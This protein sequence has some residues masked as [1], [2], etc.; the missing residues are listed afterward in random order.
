[1]VLDL[2][3]IIPYFPTPI[4]ACLF[5]STGTFAI[6][7][8][9][10]NISGTLKKP[11]ARG[12]KVLF[13]S[14]LC[15]LVLFSCS[16]KLKIKRIQY[17]EANDFYRYRYEGDEL[18]LRKKN[19]EL[20]DKT[21]FSGF[22]DSLNKMKRRYEID[23]I[24]ENDLF[25][26]SIDADLVNIYSGLI[27]ALSLKEFSAAKFY[28]GELLRMYPEA[29]KFT[30]IL[31]LEGQMWEQVPDVDSAKYHYSKFIRF[32]GSKYSR[33]FRGYV[34][35]NISDTCFTRERK[36]ALQYLKKGQYESVDSCRL[37]IEP[38]YYFE[39]FSQGFMINREDFSKKVRYIPVLN[40]NI[41]FYNK[42][43]LGIGL[44]TILNDNYALCGEVNRYNN[45]TDGQIAF[46]VEIYKVKSN[47]FGFNLSPVFYYR[48]A[49]NIEDFPNRYF[50]NAG[51][52][53]SAGFHINYK[54]YTGFSCLY[55]FFN[56]SHPKTSVFLQSNDNLYDFSL[57]Y[58]IVKGM[59]LK[60]GVINSHF[61]TGV[62]F[63]GNII[64]YDFKDS[65]IG[66]NYNFY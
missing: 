27:H 22:L 51:L 47:R 20:I 61:V 16:Y 56:S 30:D 3:K 40:F 12:S 10:I 43:Y 6:L 2:K 17:D 41:P 50:I 52:N 39:S 4:I 26:T 54:L 45:Y 63:V 9:A 62:T 48:V 31:F 37:K 65:N 13:Y 29:E 35:D 46:P 64:W 25:I 23:K 36:Y 32:S 15:C 11:I 44:L 58:Q 55:Y 18:P 7:A 34:Y 14:I 21:T 5:R 38:K 60:T 57:Y 24:K 42:F 66:L 59:S 28:S 1:M 33:R 19:N 53:A 49:D 8:F